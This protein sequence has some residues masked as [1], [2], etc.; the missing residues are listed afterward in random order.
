MSMLVPALLIALAAQPA[1][2]VELP[3]PLEAASGDIER[4]LDRANE[5]LGRAQ[6]Y[7]CQQDGA[8]EAW[9][10][11]H[12]RFDL[13]VAEARKALGREPNLDVWL[14]SCRKAGDGPRFRAL[15]SAASRHV[16]KANRLIAA[17]LARE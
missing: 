11:V 2:G 7:T 1:E 8:G 3:D 12:R 10:A 15:L 17:A 13:A 6:T 5:K 4:A 14:N 9:A 16:R